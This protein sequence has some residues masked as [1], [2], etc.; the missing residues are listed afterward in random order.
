MIRSPDRGDHVL[1]FFMLRA[2]VARHVAFGRLARRG[3]LQRLVS[4]RFLKTRELRL[5]LIA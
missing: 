5:G 3:A 1:L 4:S 2:F